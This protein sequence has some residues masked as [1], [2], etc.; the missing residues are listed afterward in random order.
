MVLILFSLR[1]WYPGGV[2]ARNY[3]G[4]GRPLPDGAVHPVAAKHNKSYDKMINS[5]EQGRATG[6]AS[7]QDNRN[8][9]NNYEL[10]GT[11]T[12]EG[13]MRIEV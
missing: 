5:S 2:L 1:V 8:M 4:W 3:D 10:V 11:G 7:Q 9:S 12:D 13:R 6:S